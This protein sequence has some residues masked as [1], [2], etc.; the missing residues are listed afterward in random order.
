MS[1][2]DQI[3]K[4]ALN[5][6]HFFIKLVH[7]NRFLGQVH[8]ELCLWMTRQDKSSHQL[9]LLPRD[10]QKSAVAA[11][12]V[13]WRIT[14][15]PSIRVLYISSTSTLATKQLKFIKDILTCPQYRKYW[16]EMIN[17]E[18]GK[19]EKWTETE[20]SIDHPIRKQEFVR[21]PTVF[22]AGL[23]T[24]IV[25]LHCDL[26]VLDDVVTD[27]N[28]F[29]EEQ[30]RKVRNQVSYLASIAGTDSDQIV[31]GT[32][33]H[34]KDLY[35]DF[36]QMKY[37]IYDDNGNIIDTKFLYET[38]Q[39]QVESVGDG[40]GEFLWPRTQRSDGKW[41]GFNTDILSKKKAQYAN[42][43]SFRSQYY[44]DPNTTEDSP[45]KPEHF[46]YYDPAFLNKGQYGKWYYKNTRLNVFASIDFA[47]S[48]GKKSDFTSLCVVGV[49]YKNNYYIL[50]IVRFKTDRISDYYQA[51]VKAYNKWGFTKLRAE[52][53]AAQQ[54]IVRDLKENYIKPNGL[55]LSVEEYRPIKNKQERIAST[56]EPRYVNLQV[57][58]YKNG[59]CSLLEEELL[60][61]R[62]AHDDIKDSL[63]ACIDICV[64]PSYSHSDYKKST[65]TFKFQ[66]QTFNSRFGGI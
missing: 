38:F 49:D 42:K 15:N 43:A 65:P 32:R 46:Q 59:N 4:Q 41:F 61:A 2:K 64:A 13:A 16:P 40:T 35:A 9:V 29:N 12:Y 14:K 25:G 31:V 57:W 21:D 66:P 33:Y 28:S 37:E 24:A 19:R 52:I 17:E 30:R 50:D 39:R 11:Y 18:E 36:I 60:Q 44:N 22:T 20:I 48:L 6:F 54:I 62:P 8:E 26:S 7:P 56:L 1:V 34:P 45:I 10:H 47:Y 53:T 63:T 3:I 51:I 27:E 23:N 5:D 58:H 55:I